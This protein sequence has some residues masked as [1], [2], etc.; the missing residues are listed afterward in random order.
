[1]ASSSS[2]AV[3]ERVLKRANPSTIQGK[4]L[5]GY[6]G[7]FT[8]AG[9]GE[10]INPGHHG[11]LHWF[12]KP[13]PEGGRPHLDLWPDVS[14][15]DSSELYPAPG[16]KHKNGE[17][18]M[19][20]SS[21][22]AQ[23][24]QRHFRWMGEHGVDGAFLQ[25]FATQCDLEAGSEGIRRLRDE[26][27]DRVRE[28]AE[29]EGRV[30]AIM[31]DVTGVP[32]ERIQRVLEH[33]WLHLVQK[34]GVLNSPNYLKENGKPVVALWGFG[35]EKGGHT[36]A[37]V[38][39]ITQ[40]FRN[41]TPGGVYLMA[42]TPS[43]WR[44]AEGDA[45]SNPVFR[46]LFL[47]EF[48][49]ISPWT[50]G[51]YKSEAEADSFTENR[52]KGDFELVQMHNEQSGSRKV[53]YIPV[54]WPGG[55][56]NNLTQGKWGFNDAPRKGGR[57]LWKQ[58]FNA[59][60]VGA[61]I[62]YGA[63]WDEY[64]EGTAFMPAVSYKRNLPVSDTWSFLALDQEG[65]DLPSDWYMRV[66]GFAAEVLRGERRPFETFPSKELQDFWGTRPK[67][68]DILV[69]SAE[70]CSSGQA[71]AVAL[72]A[73]GSGGTS[74][75]GAMNKD[76]SYEQWSSSLQGKDDEPPPPPYSLEMDDPK[77]APTAQPARSSTVAGAGPTAPSGMA[78]YGPSAATTTGHVGPTSNV[79]PPVSDRPGFSGPPPVN[80]HTYPTGHAHGSQP[81][82]NPNASPIATAHSDP[83][84][85][86]ANNFGRV[87]L[88][89]PAPGGYQPGH[90]SVSPPPVHP[91]HPAAQQQ[92]RPPTRPHTSASN[93]NPSL[94]ASYSP[95]QSTSPGST[96]TTLPNQAS[97]ATWQHAQWTPAKW[98]AGMAGNSTPASSSGPG[99]GGANG[100][101]YVGGANLTR[102]QTFTAS[103]GPGGG[104]ALQ[105]SSTVSYSRP[106]ASSNATPLHHSATLGQGRPGMANRPQSSSGSTSPQSTGFGGGSL[107]YS[108]GAPQPP[109]QMGPYG[110]SSAPGGAATYGPGYQHPS[111][112][113]SS[114]ASS[115]QPSA[116]SSASS[117]AAAAY[118]PTG[119]MPSGPSGYGAPG[120]N[121]NHNHTHNS[122]YMP[123]FPGPGAMSQTSI[124]ESYGPQAYGGYQQSG[125]PPA[126]PAGSYPSTSVPPAG[127]SG[128]GGEYCGGGGAGA[129]P[130]A[131]SG[132]GS[133]SGSASGGAPGS[134]GAVGVSG[135][136]NANVYSDG[137]YGHSGY[138]V[139]QQ[140]VPNF[141]SAL[142][143]EGGQGQYGASAMP[144][145]HSFQSGPVAQ[146]YGEGYGEGGYGP[147]PPVGYFGGEGA[148]G[149]GQMQQPAP[150][151]PGT[152]QAPPALPPRPG[153]SHSN[154]GNGYGSY[155]KP[156]GSSGFAGAGAGAMGFA[157]SAVD[158]VA[159]RKT[160]E[161]L[162]SGVG[163]LAQSGSKLLS[164]F[165][166]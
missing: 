102:P 77:P 127:N 50:V 145:A 65:Q 19:L 156:G 2:S 37:L 52:M 35:F 135:F 154:S 58:V 85:K 74:G 98:P 17:Q 71:P 143:G 25:R 111:S 131:W 10:A 70:P 132:H 28:A 5:V 24:V 7:W 4:F 21:R 149:G 159:G 91:A 3:A 1:M 146:G 166:K 107:S 163:S 64:D 110:A 138:G 81:Y 109:A 101:G 66:C 97:S 134:P 99:L 155:G 41:T 136:P 38:H 165:T 15:Y 43:Q 73:A 103:S 115:A 8:C 53:D 139:Q 157:W 72:T 147:P 36:P 6:Q 90:P 89:G 56:A 100:S 13:I 94:Q 151:V 133:A 164:K 118:A 113:A 93:V 121:H 51:R 44:T 23:T 40:F 42:G 31:Y 79:Q 104:T 49:A 153:N 29:R 141:P 48:D 84:S 83:V 14:S 144:L 88:N 137:G 67:Y 16:L 116:S 122:S 152:G 106:G 148:V 142:G 161:Q 117:A 158:K 92:G 105:H 76:Q 30:F 55:S 26:I 114:S 22:N 57:F 32:A 125:A 12:D 33:D 119:I 108:G 150:W 82:G 140:Q 87:D 20:F 86:L 68:E 11:W 128:V 162:E 78:P 62:M 39:A 9:D 61:R 160:R 124:S 112:S 69:P 130:L 60:K 96:S 45:D 120:H 34:K 63:M 95:P 18:V 75:A 46:D 27:G 54:V 80:A 123:G 59:H 126:F 47:N 129:Y